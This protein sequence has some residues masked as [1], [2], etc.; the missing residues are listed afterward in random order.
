MRDELGRFSTGHKPTKEENNLRISKYKESIRKSEWFTGDIKIENAY[1]FNSWRAIM[2]TKKGK[3][4]GISET[5]KL[6]KNFYVDV[7][8]TYKVGLRLRRLDKTLPFSKDNFNWLS[9]SEISIIDTDRIMLSY[10][11]KELSIAEWAAILSKS[12]SSI[13]NRYHKHKDW[14][15]E[16]ILFGR[17]NKKPKIIKDKSECENIRA[18]VS[19]MCSSYKIKDS[20]KRLQYDLDIDW[21]IN[22]IINKKCE[23]CGDNKNIGCDRIDNSIG[24]TKI[25]VIPCCYTCNV[26]RNNIFTVEEMKELGKSI[27]RIKSKRAK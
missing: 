7:S 26:V 6:F 9:D 13:R 23:Y 24:H 21:F 27:A 1:I 15:I 19:K 2:Y 10:D 8:P 25:N 12:Q 16:E 3:M 18:K 14:P 4:A 5:W 11:N 22:N 20:N 17:K